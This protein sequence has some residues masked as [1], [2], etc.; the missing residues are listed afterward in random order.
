MTTLPSPTPTM[1]GYSKAL[2]VVQRVPWELQLW[3]CSPG[4]TSE[5]RVGSC[6]VRHSGQGEV[7]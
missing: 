1:V 7:G 3:H 2:G 6:V 4:A 5:D